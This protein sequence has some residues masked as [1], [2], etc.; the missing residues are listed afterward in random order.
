MR[1][2]NEIIALSNFQARDSARALCSNAINYLI[3]I[4]YGQTILLAFLLDHRALN[5]LSLIFDWRW[6]ILLCMACALN[7]KQEKNHT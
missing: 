3:L 2:L 7:L 4:H 6:S 5:W 1:A